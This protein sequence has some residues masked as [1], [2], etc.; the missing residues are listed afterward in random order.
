ME[1]ILKNAVISKYSISDMA[2]A[3]EAHENIEISFTR[4]E[5]SYTSFDLTG[6][7]LSST[8]AGYDVSKATSL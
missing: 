1:H 4:I 8:S 7:A 5:S 2:G 6:K 3:D